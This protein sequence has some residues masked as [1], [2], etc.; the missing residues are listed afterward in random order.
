M[1]KAKGFPFQ[2]FVP[3]SNLKLF[4]FHRN[5]YIKGTDTR[6][7]FS[8]LPSSRPHKTKRKCEE[9]RKEKSKIDKFWQNISWRWLFFVVVVGF[10]FDCNKCFS[11][12]ALWGWEKM[13]SLNLNRITPV[14]KREEKKVC[15]M[16]SVMITKGIYDLIE[17]NN[18]LMFLFFLPLICL[19][20]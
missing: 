12:V 5:K 16:C 1:T 8:V 13:V 14:M 3:S 17:E 18:S 9:K 2:V 11:S 4:H 15:C 20:V 10:C 7:L 19:F 6:K